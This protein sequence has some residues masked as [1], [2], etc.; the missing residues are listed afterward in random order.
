M[1]M[2]DKKPNAVYEPGELNRVRKKLGDMDLSE[3]RRMAQILGGEVG[4]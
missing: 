3:A 4:T 1:T 2:E